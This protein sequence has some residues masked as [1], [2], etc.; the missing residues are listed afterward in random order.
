M[1]QKETS[2]AGFLI[3]PWPSFFW[4]RTVNWGWSYSPP[5]LICSFTFHLKVLIVMIPK[6]FRSWSCFLLW[7]YSSQLEFYVTGLP[8]KVS[9]S[10]F[11]RS[12]DCSTDSFPSEV[13]LPLLE[14][15]TRFFSHPGA[16]EIQVSRNPCGH[17]G[18]HW[19]V[20]CPPMGQLFAFLP[21]PHQKLPV[22]GADLCLSNC[23][24]P[25]PIHLHPGML[26]HL[27]GWRLWNT[28]E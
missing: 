18:L 22:L 1:E 28:N 11:S 9:L 8:I 17:L 12:S 26:L 2:E 16:I 6:N 3:W 15:S 14:L 19:T 10:P 7:P 4:G 13:G 23:P 24:F 21:V 25:E 20:L 27:R 5:A